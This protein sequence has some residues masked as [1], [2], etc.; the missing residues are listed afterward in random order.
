[1]KK[2]WLNRLF[3]GIIFGL[4]L[5]LPMIGKTTIMAKAESTDLGVVSVINAKN[6]SSG[7]KI[8]WN[9]V[10]GASGYILY[11]TA[12]PGNDI[13]IETFKISGGSKVSYID[14]STKN[15]VRY[16]YDAI[17][18]KGDIAG[19]E[20]DAAYIVRVTDVELTYVK[21]LSS[22]V[23][24]IKWLKNSKA[25]GYQIYCSTSKK[26][27]NNTVK[28]TV[29]KSGKNVCKFTKMKTGKT[30]YVKIRAYKTVSGTKSYS[31]WS[32]V[33]KVKITK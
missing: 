12:Y 29:Q 25:S 5:M 13:I 10:P 3:V 20:G 2:V 15:G 27:K 28:Y 16:S 11:R 32:K 19:L 18:T 6:T 22:R 1:M 4:M 23:L 17:A 8:T 21:N 9:K 24:K 14:K 30:Y 31:A 26:F 33:K 7:I